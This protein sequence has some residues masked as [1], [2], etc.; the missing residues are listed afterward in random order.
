MTISKREKNL[1]RIARYYN[2]PI[3]MKTLPEV[4]INF[5]CNEKPLVRSLARIRKELEKIS[6]LTLTI[7]IETISV[8]K[9]WW[10]F[11]K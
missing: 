7:N 5:K 1:I 3:K 11:W 8:K 4:Q 6:K 9:Q 10:Q 2:Y